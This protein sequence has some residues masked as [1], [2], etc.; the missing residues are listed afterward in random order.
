MGASIPDAH[1]RARCTSRSREADRDSPLSPVNPNRKRVLW[2]DNEMRMTDASVR[3]LQLAGFQVECANCAAEGLRLANGPGYDGIILDLWLPDAPGLNLLGALR[4]KQIQTPVLVFTRFGDVASAAAAMRLGAL[5]VREKPIM[6][7]ELVTVVTALVI[8]RPAPNV[9]VDS[10]DARERLSI[11]PT[12]IGSFLTILDSFG[13]HSDGAAEMH[14]LIVVALVKA[15]LTVDLSIPPLL[16]CAQMFRRVLKSCD[17]MSILAVDARRVVSLATQCSASRQTDRVSLALAWLA[18]E[19]A[20]NRRPSGVAFA[21]VLG[22][23]RSHA[24]RVVHRE[25]GLSF[26]EWRWGLELRIALSDLARTDA[27]IKSIAAKL[28]FD[29]HSQFDRQFNRT[30]GLS[31]TEF[32]E[33]CREVRSCC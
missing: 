23:E 16:A 31:P 32:R 11:S 26:P 21:G 14:G 5:D 30:I 2:I 24:G 17:D 25:T 13:R 33:M 6:A 27:P 9:S 1:C 19:V 20:A 8:G 4:E 7:D 29:H 15:L 18:A 3:F 22:I 12:G 28:G 10:H